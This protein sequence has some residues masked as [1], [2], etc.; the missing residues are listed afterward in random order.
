MMRS[1]VLAAALAL[2]ACDHTEYVYP[3]AG[4]PNLDGGPTVSDAGLFCTPRAEFCVNAVIW[5]CTFNGTDADFSAD[6]SSGTDG[7]Y[8]VPSG[9]C[10]P[11]KSNG[12]SPQFSC[13]DP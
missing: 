3:D 8:C 7:G 4:M 13:C 1:I 10:P 5:Q 2:C 6:C 12:G 9:Q 11:G